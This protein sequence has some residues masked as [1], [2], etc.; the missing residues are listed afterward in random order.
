MRK[1]FNLG[2]GGL[3]L[4]AVVTLVTAAAFGLNPGLGSA[5]QPSQAASTSAK[6]IAAQK[7]IAAQVTLRAESWNNGYVHVW[8]NLSESSDA[9]TDV[10]ESASCIRLDDATYKLGSGSTTIRYYKLACNGVIGYVEV[11][12]VR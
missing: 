7:A 11:D 9:Y 3:L 5:H 4:I 8:A 6:S 10:P 1:I 2:C 12:Q